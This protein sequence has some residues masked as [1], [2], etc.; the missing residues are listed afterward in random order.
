M[1]CERLHIR[2]CTVALQLEIRRRRRGLAEC[3]HR[4]AV[5]PCP[6]TS[7]DVARARGKERASDAR[8]GRKLGCMRKY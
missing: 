8:A 1:Q 5:E 3:I 4:L 2:M 6:V 7:A